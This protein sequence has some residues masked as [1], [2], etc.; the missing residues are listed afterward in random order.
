[1]CTHTSIFSTF[2][3]TA[4]NLSGIPWVVAKI[5]TNERLSFKSKKHFLQRSSRLTYLLTK[6]ISPFGIHIFDINWPDWY[7]YNMNDILW[8]LKFIISMQIPWGQWRQNPSPLE[9]AIPSK[10]AQILRE[11]KFRSTLSILQ[12]GALEVEIKV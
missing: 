7:W 11:F 5:L 6:I 8:I 3:S 1:M 10:T 4:I 2:T 9:L 12:V